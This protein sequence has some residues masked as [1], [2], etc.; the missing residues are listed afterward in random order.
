M[1][2]DTGRNTVNKVNVTIVF[3]IPQGV[4]WGEGFWYTLYR[5]DLLV[6]ENDVRSQEKT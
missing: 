3:R 1:M 2:H 6:I 4:W 5:G